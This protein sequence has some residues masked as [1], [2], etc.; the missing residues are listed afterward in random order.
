MYSNLNLGELF[1]KIA[2][3]N[4]HKIALNFLDGSQVSFNELNEKSD[5]FYNWIKQNRASINDPICILS[6]KNKLVFFVLIGCLKAGNPY[7]VLDK[8]NPDKRNL[9]VIKTLNPKLIFSAIKYKGAISKLRNFIS[10]SK[11]KIISKR[12]KS[13]FKKKKF[14]LNT[15]AYNMF[16]SGSTGDPKGVSISHKNVL[17]FIDW[18]KNE[19]KIKQKDVFSNL[20]GLHFD[21]SIFDIFGG[22]FNG[23]T[24]VPVNKEDLLDPKEFFRLSKKINITTWFSVPS[25]LIY[26]MNFN[27]VIKSNFKNYLN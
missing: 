25:L 18:S 15:L 21:N 24:I 2:N 14:S 19:Y 3:K 12:K 17:N 4:K 16:T 7:T 11:V 22:L 6:N 27:A 8:D 23:V 26:F 20:N 10:L 1:E 5:L 9:K 13:Q